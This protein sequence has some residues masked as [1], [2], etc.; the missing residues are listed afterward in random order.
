MT[1]AHQNN[2]WDVERDLWKLSF[3]IFPRPNGEM[4]LNRQ[5]ERGE[6]KEVRESLP[7]FGHV[8]Q[9]HDA[10]AAFVHVEKSGVENFLFP[11]LPLRHLLLLLI[12]VR[13]GVEYL[14]SSFRLLL[15]DFPCSISP[16]QSH[17]PN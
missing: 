3:H 5:T 15:L 13:C 12:L 8:K 2:D 14:K 1:Q 16:T 10:I 6:Q 4:V 7:H 17:A 11:S 9:Q